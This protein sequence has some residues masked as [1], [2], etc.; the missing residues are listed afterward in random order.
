MKLVQA[1]INQGGITA[2][3]TGIL[4]QGAIAAQTSSPCGEPAADP[5]ALKAEPQQGPEHRAG[6][7]QLGGGQGATQ[8]LQTGSQVMT[9]L[10]KIPLN[11]TE[12]LM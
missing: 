2:A 11:K 3:F 4:L 12:K 10:S 6:Q 7:V 8:R 1:V 9:G 5:E